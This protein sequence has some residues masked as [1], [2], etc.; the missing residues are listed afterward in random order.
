MRKS[1]QNLAVL[2]ISFSFYCCSTTLSNEQEVRAEIEKI[3]KI[4]EDAYDMNNEEGRQLLKS[5]CDDSLIFVGGDNGGIAMTSDYYVHDLAD[6]YKKRPYD[7]TIRIHDNTVV[8]SCLQ[9]TF[10][11]FNTDTIYF[12]SRYTKVFEKKV[13][14][15]KMIY[16]TYSPI[17]VLYFEQKKIDTAILRNYVGLYRE[18]ST[19]VDTVV[20]VDGKLM[21]SSTGGERAELKPVNETMFIGDGYFGM[22]GFSK[23]ERGRVNGTYFEFVDGQRIHF[24]RMQ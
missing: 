23:D 10:K 11:V 8:V 3:L 4:Q 2:I 6:G 20:L 12:N 19:I 16:V 15:W 1:I 18:S 13:K 17:P 24:E 14:G 21:M 9:Q 7:K 22:T 5:T